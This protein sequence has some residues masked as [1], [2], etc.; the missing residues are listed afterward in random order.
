MNFE[1]KQAKPECLVLLRMG[2]RV[3][4]LRRAKPGGRRLRHPAEDSTFLRKALLYLR[5]QSDRRI[6]SCKVAGVPNLRE[7]CQQRLH[8]K[9]LL[10]PHH[11]QFPVVLRPV[12]QYPR[13]HAS[14]IARCASA[15]S[16]QA[17]WVAGW[18]S[19]EYFS[20]VTLR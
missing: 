5:W 15:L 6:S 14:W 8:V 17:Q 10:I 9:V 11:D 4:P 12:A 19:P 18:Q 1:Q 3:L 20:G 2:V 7:I 13:Y 16:P